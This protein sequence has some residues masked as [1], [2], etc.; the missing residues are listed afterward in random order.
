MQKTDTLNHT[1]YVI[2]KSVTKCSK[3]TVTVLLLKDTGY[4][5]YQMQNRD[6]LKVVQQHSQTNMLFVKKTG[7]KTNPKMYDEDKNIVDDPSFV[8]VNKGSVSVSVGNETWTIVESFAN[9]KAVD[10]QIYVSHSVDRDGFIDISKA[11]KET[12]AQ[13]NATE[14][15]VTKALKDLKD[16]VAPLPNFLL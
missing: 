7:T 10:K 12:T 8:A 15:E 2:L 13:I 9:S 3:Y 16:A 11:M 4:T 6:T 14:S 5:V 1:T